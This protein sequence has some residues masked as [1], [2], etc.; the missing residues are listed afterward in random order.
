MKRCLLAVGLMVSA[1]LAVAQDTSVQPGINRAYDGADYQ[2]WQG[3]F[4]TEGREVFEKRE[5]IIAALDIRPGMGIADVGAGTGAFSFPLARKVGIT[6]KV[7][8]QD[9]SPEFLRG[10]EARVRK[11]NLPQLHSLLGA[12]KEAR[13]APSSVDMVF[14][15]DTY[16]HFEYPQAMLASLHQALRPSGRLIVIDYERLPGRSSP[17][18]L[19]HVRAGRE[20]VVTEIEAAG[21]KLLRSHQFL[22]ENFFIEFVR[23]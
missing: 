6:G 3:M 8:A 19:G 10:I 18:V 20:T 17:W 1:V 4:E 11:E 13:L 7:I 14:T 21:F 12:E 16:H 22:R 23:P 5:A 15:C 2:R 9:I